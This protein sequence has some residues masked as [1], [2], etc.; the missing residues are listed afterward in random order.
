MDQL[1]KIN[2]LVERGIHRSMEN[3]IR[4]IIGNLDFKTLFLNSH[5]LT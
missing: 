3:T 5:F 4:E 2:I 1:L